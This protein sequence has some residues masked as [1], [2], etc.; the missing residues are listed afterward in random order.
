M[1]IGS[2]SLQPKEAQKYPPKVKN[3]LI[4][5][6]SMQTGRMAEQQIEDL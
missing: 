4:T 1:D 6:C 3:A 2:G 5:S